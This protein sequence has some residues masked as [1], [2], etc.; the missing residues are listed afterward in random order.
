MEMHYHISFPIAF[1]GKG[2][3]AVGQTRN[4]N[5]TKQ[6]AEFDRRHINAVTLKLANY[7]S[8]RGCDCR[9]FRRGKPQNGESRSDHIFPFAAYSGIINYM[10]YFH[11]RRIYRGVVTT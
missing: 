8:F 7:T 5:K 1:T 6:S 3:N 10:Q 4:S 11:N 9:H 2:Y